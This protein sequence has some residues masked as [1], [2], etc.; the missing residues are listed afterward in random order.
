MANQNLTKYANPGETGGNYEG[1][2]DYSG[3]SYVSSASKKNTVKP[4]QS[5]E[6]MNANRMS[7]HSSYNQLLPTPVLYNS[8][9]PLVPYRNLQN[10]NKFGAIKNN[11]PTVNQ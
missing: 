10:L 2:E 4:H 9:S 3:S 6:E 8:Q 7:F 11:F 1:G 5:D